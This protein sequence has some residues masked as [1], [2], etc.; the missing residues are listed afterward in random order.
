[1]AL[2]YT[3]QRFHRHVMHSSSFSTPEITGH[4]TLCPSQR[5][6]SGLPNPAHQPKLPMNIWVRLHS[7]H[8]NSH[9][10]V[11]QSA[12]AAQGSRTGW[13]DSDPLAGGWKIW[14]TNNGHSRRDYARKRTYLVGYH[15]IWKREPDSICTKQC[16]NWILKSVG[17]KLYWKR[18]SNSGDIQ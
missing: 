14:H 10:C 17:T 6:S 3:S 1:M 11:P 16:W 18:I 2:T 12:T 13:G 8:R 9:R 4:W 5:P 15:V 7:P